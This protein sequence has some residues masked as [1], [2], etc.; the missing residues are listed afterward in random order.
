MKCLH[1]VLPLSLLLFAVAL[2]VSGK[3]KEPT[4]SAAGAITE[5]PA[6][7]VPASAPIQ[8]ASSAASISASAEASAP[9][10]AAPTASQ[11]SATLPASSASAAASI[12]SVAT[13]GLNWK[14][15]PR[16]IALLDQATIKI[17]QDF[18][19]LEQED[20]R[21]LLSKLG[22]PNTGDVSGLFTGPGGNWLLVVRF[23]KSGYVAETEEPDWQPDELLAKLKKNVEET[24]EIRKK[25]GVSETEILTWIEKPNY[26]AKRHRLIWAVSSREKN[27][28]ESDFQSV[29]FNMYVLGREGYFNFSLVSDLAQLDQNKKYAASLVS[30]VVFKDGKKYRDFKKGTDK[31]SPYTVTGLVAVDEVAATDKKEAAPA[32]TDSKMVKFAKVF[33]LILLVIL[34]LA[35]A[36]GGAY[37]F[38]RK[39]RAAKL[40]AEV[41]AETPPAS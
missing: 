16:D 6:S 40:A 31:M 14:I 11:A 12:N 41:A 19:Y 36:A 23:N 39:R 4:T 22:N 3:G 5:A 15:G 10:A 13:P 38:M 18:A 33:G 2:P 8:S 34:G 26:D 30:S 1:S 21:Q 24:N 32:N 37:Y 17:P 25:N 35:G 29:N 27:G 7:S 28:K 9:A 20:A